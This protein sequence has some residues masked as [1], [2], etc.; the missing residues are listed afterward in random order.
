[1]LHLAATTDKLRLV[2]S[3]AATIDVHMS[4][5]DLNTST[6]DITH[7][8]QNT[9]ISTATT[10]DILAAPGANVVRRLK[11]MTARN[12]HATVACVVTV[13]FD[14]NGTVFELHS[15]F[16]PPGSALQYMEG[17]GFFRSLNNARPYANVSVADEVAN[18]TDTYLT[19]SAI[20]IPTSAPIAVGTVFR[21]RFCMTKTA[22]GTAQAIWSVRFGTNGTTADTARLTPTQTAQT[23]AA[24][25]GFAT[26]DVIVRGPIGA[27]CVVHGRFTMEHHLATT[28]LQDQNHNVIQAASAAFDCT[29]AGMIVGVSVNPGASGVWTFQQVTAEVLNL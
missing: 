19:G 14:Q 6:R 17:Y 1:M 15:E 18:A 22:A 2:T 28:G 10:T 25:T 20:A 24:D 13:T 29:T 8:K 9:A 26:I 4:Y 27:S 16:L 3:A 7:G 23:A 12:K 21:W 5:A 11:A